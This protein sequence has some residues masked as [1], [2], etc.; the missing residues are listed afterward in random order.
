MSTLS[1]SVCVATE[2]TT[3]RLSH[4]NN[5]ILLI[6]IVYIWSVEFKLAMNGHRTSPLGSQPARMSGPCGGSDIIGDYGI[7][8]VLLIQMHMRAARSYVGPRLHGLL[9]KQSIAHKGSFS[10]HCGDTLQPELFKQL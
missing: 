9:S 7:W 8:V 3:K 6:A 4:W 1:N 5:G 2:R 10:W